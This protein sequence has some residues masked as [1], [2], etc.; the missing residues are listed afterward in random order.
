[1]YLIH[2]ARPWQD[3]IP[4]YD[5]QDENVAVWKE[6]EQLYEEKLIRS[7]G[8]SNFHERDLENLLARTMVIPVINQIKYHP[9]HP[10]RCDRVL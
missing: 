6:M 5:Y 1:M 9:G 4:N 10:N 2:N 8:V 3:A 7:I